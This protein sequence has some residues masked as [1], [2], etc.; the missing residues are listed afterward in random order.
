M[1][2]V[3]ACPIC[4]RELLPEAKHAERSRDAVME[5]SGTK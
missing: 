4:G 5:Q 2:C 1:A 3:Q